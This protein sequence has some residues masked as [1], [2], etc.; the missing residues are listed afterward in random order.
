MLI[1][2][3]SA[4]GLM[5]IFFFG[6]SACHLMEAKEFEH[7]RVGDRFVYT[8]DVLFEGYYV[9]SY[10]CA[11]ES[12]NIDGDRYMRNDGSDWCAKNGALAVRNKHIQYSIL[13]SDGIV[14]R[15][16]RYVLDLWP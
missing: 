10:L 5:G 4:L 15:I 6:L 8:E 2:Q 12:I 16:D 9:Y 14:V 1:L 13:T 3:T 11:R 7:L